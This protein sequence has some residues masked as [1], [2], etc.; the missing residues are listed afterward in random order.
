MR[1]LPF[2]LVLFLWC[3]FA[4]AQ[5]DTTIWVIETT[6]GNE[7]TGWITSETEEHI[8]LETETYGALTIPIKN[9]AKRKKANDSQIVDGEYWFDNP[10]ASRY[11]WAPNGYGL[12]KGEGYYQNTW[13]LLNQVSYGFTDNFTVG[14]GIVPTFFFGLEA[15]PVWVTPKFSF[16][17][18][19]DKVNLGAGVLA[20]TIVGEDT[21][22]VGLTYGLATVGDRDRNITLGVG[23]GFVEGD[24]AETPVIMIGGMYRV[25][26]KGY[27]LTE[28]YVIPAFDNEVAVLISGGG[29][30]VGKKI[31]IDY[32]GVLPIASGMDTF[33]II[34]WLGIN[35]PTENCLLISVGSRQY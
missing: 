31:A 22:I 21:E 34:P 23:Y 25:G 35:V 4:G 3:T 10:H 14:V 13:I 20:G 11:Y 32:G 15:A 26:K 29:R 9:I 16:P 1:K 8:V 28:N 5:T 19:K 7:Y 30:W 27:L 18:V 17:V 2:F 6:D 33:I 12:R 24:W